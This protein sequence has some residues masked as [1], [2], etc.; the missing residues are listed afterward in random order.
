MPSARTWRPLPA[1]G[2]PGPSRPSRIRT[3]PCA[4]PSAGSGIPRSCCTTMRCAASSSTST[5]AYWKRCSSTATSRPV[6]SHRPRPRRRPARRARS[7]P[8][9]WPPNRPTHIRSAPKQGPRLAV[10]DAAHQQ[11]RAIED[12]LSADRTPDQAACERAVPERDTRERD[13]PDQAV[14]DQAVRVGDGPERAAGDRNTRTTN[15]RSPLDADLLIDFFD[16]HGRNLPWRDPAA[17]PWAV[18]VSEVMLQQTPVVRA[19]P[20]FFEWLAR[21][22]APEDL[23]ADSPA[24][25][26]RAWGR[27]GY[28]RRALRL[29]AAATVITTEH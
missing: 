2:R 20:V 23:A 18:L 29:H 12:L 19:L 28:P 21:W 4:S 9:R 16:R 26:I 15:P 24:A 11:D 10:T 14:P 3:T 7:S 17:S 22:P 27:L 5:P 6:S 25:A 8:K 1:T 13:T